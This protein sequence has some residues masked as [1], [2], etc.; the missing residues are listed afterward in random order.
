MNLSNAASTSRLA[1]VARPQAALPPGAPLLPASP[2]SATPDSD[3]AIR[4][5]ENAPVRVR[6]LATG[7]L[8]E[9]SVSDPVQRVDARDAPPLLNTRYF[10]RAG[11]PPTP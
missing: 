4:C 2:S 9:F 11:S 10:R 1:R 8:Y 7:R 3:V 6:G 5:L